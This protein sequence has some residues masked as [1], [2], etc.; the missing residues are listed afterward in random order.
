MN[1]GNN[2]NATTGRYPIPYAKEGTFSPLEYAKYML[3]LKAAMSAAGCA[4]AWGATAE[5]DLDTA[6][7]A[8]NATLIQRAALKRNI[9][10]VGICTIAFFYQQWF[11]RHGTFKYQRR[12][13]WR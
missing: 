8:A 11:T 9:S 4:A 3:Q 6:S 5:T 13:A 10:A 7:E 1:Q 2:L 12:L